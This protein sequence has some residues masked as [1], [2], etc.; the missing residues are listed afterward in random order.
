MAAA[1]LV[2]SATTSLRETLVRY[3]NPNFFQVYT[4]P[5]LQTALPILQYGQIRVAIYELDLTQASGLDF[6][7]WLNAG[8]S[9]IHSLLLCDQ[10]DRELIEIF[11][12][13]RAAMLL[14][15]ELNPD[16]LNHRLKRL[17][18]YPR[19][20]TWEFNQINLFQLAHLASHVRQTRHIYITSTRT[21]QEGILCFSQGKVLHA[22]YDTF[23]GEEAF[24]EIIQMKQGLFQ[25]LPIDTEAADTITASMERLMAQSA[26]I[27]D[28]RSDSAFAL[29]ARCVFLTPDSSLA[30][31]FE[32][33]CPD[34]QLEIFETDQVGEAL[35]QLETP[36]DVWV[37]DLDCPDLNPVQVLQALQQSGQRIE[38]LL[39][40]SVFGPDVPAL[41]EFS[42]VRRFFLKPL[43]YPE[44]KTRLLETYLNQNFSGK[45]QQLS[46]LDVLQ[47]LSYFRSSC[48]LEVLD[49]FSGDSG[50]IFIEQGVLQHAAFGA[51]SGRDALREMLLIYAGVFRQEPY[52][53]PV[54]TSFNVPLIRLFLYLGR[55][56]EKLHAAA[57]LPRELLLQNGRLISLQP[58]RVE[59]LIHP[60]PN[61]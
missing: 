33:E 11:R 14:K 9:R 27:L 42:A 3:L 10:P 1:V 5:D 40:G 30:R 4:A 26:L 12:R 47:T 48:L 16:M 32:A 43:Q 22:L 53:T 23:S 6:L 38:V 37:I 41:M 35:M 24:Y 21:A 39:I 61:S 52:Y 18:E 36:G 56:V 57:H 34:A 25:E 7:L 58:D 51:L 8:D 50:S 13:Q 46:L 28:Q 44:L 54:Q 29:P 31:Y 15:D 59:N 2:I 19:G 17:L 20:L 45:M 49:F 60:G 55:L